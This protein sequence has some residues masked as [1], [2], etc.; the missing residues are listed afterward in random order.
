MAAS[1]GSDDDFNA[2]FQI[3]GVDFADYLGRGVLHYAVASGDLHLVR[4][5]LLNHLLPA[6]ALHATDNFGHNPYW[7]ARQGGDPSIMEL[8]IDEGAQH[9]SEES[10]QSTLDHFNCIT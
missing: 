6:S 3:L 2:C 4:R 9:H 10:D 5:L 7:Y 1:G 8:L